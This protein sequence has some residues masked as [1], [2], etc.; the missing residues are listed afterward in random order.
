[1]ACTTLIW[2]VVMCCGG[3]ARRRPRC[4]IFFPHFAARSNASKP[5]KS[6]SLAVT[7]F[8]L[9]DNR[10]L[11][12]P[13]STEALNA[14]TIVESF[15]VS[16]LETS[17]THHIFG[18]LTIGL[19]GDDRDHV[20]MLELWKIMRARSIGLLQLAITWYKI[21]YAGGQA[22]YYSRTGTLKQKDPNQWSLTCVCFD[23]PVQE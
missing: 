18:N 1:M 12:I 16:L 22:H 10:M 20:R 19:R 21:C 7:V 6:T 4:R 3:R 15:F 23:V 17:A 2:I 14:R 9:S 8:A 13:E 5:S 11:S